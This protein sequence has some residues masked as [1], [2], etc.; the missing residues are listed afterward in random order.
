MSRA[1][2]ENVKETI[3]RQRELENIR[4]LCEDVAAF[5]YQP[6]KCK[7]P[8]RIVVVRKTLSVEQG[9]WVLYDD[10]RYFFSL[11]SG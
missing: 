8:Y 1:Q 10:V 5:D 11:L 3:V 7:K 9:D 6:T 4:L 2:P